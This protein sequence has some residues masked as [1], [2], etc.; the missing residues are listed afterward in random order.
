VSDQGVGIP[1][2]EQT[3]IFEP[4]A[5]ASTAPSIAEGTGLGLYLAAKIVERHGGTIG[6]QSEPGHG[7]IF[8]IRLPLHPPG[9]TGTGRSAIQE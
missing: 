3:T 4:F 5:R 1:R 2:A 9:G 8:T 7:S 6:V